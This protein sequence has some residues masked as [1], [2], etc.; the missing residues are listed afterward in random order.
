M[1]NQ[2]GHID[3]L[4]TSVVYGDSS[5]LVDEEAKDYVMWIDSFGPNNRKYFESVGSSPT[6]PN[7]SIEKPPVL[8]E[9]SLPSH[10]KY[11]YLGSTS[12]LPVII[13]SYLS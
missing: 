6:R 9:K 2:K 13:S 1:S 10:V 11:A 8:E 5:D 7:P 4:E 3:P 12:T